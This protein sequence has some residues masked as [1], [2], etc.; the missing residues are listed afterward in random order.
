MLFRRC[1][2]GACRCPGCWGCGCTGSCDERGAS[3]MRGGCHSWTVAADLRCGSGGRVTLEL[4]QQEI[5]GE[6]PLAVLDARDPQDAGGSWRVDRDCSPGGVS[7]GEG[8][9]GA[10]DG[11]RL[12]ERDLLDA[13]P[14]V[15]LVAEI[16]IDFED[17]GNCGAGAAEWIRHVHPL[18]SAARSAAACGRAWE[19]R[20]RRKRRA[21]GGCRG[22]VARP[23]I[24]SAGRRQFL[25]DRWGHEAR[26]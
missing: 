23:W 5:A 20:W 18:G 17:E 10:F 13:Q 1:D 25:S 12:I 7:D 15:G 8:P 9:S 2:E 11:V 19:G 26:Y 14:P 16:E 22:G 6:H 21:K 24:G 4:P 3:S